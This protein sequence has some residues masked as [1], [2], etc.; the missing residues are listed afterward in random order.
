MNQHL[1]KQL[2]K[3]EYAA[4]LLNIAKGDL[5]SAE[6]LSKVSKGRPENIVFLAQQSVEKSIKSVLIHLQV[7]FPLVHDLGILIALLPEEKAPQQGFSLTELNPFASARRYEE[8]RIPLSSE[9]IQ[10]SIEVAK[11]ITDWATKIIGK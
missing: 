9:E 10:T 7:A 8:G 2:F 11:K 5:E 6:A 1:K 4:E 3:K